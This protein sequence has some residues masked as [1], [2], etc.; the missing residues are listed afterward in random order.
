MLKNQIIIAIRNLTRQKG[1][2][3]I[4]ICGLTIGIT[5]CL[6]ILLYVS[7]EM[8][9]DRYH[10]NVDNIYRIGTQGII[11]PNEFKVAVT[12]APMGPAFI[13]EI[14]EVITAV[15]IR[16]FGF[17]VLTYKDKVFSEERFFSVDSTIFSI[18]T[19]PFLKGDPETALSKPNTVVITESMAHKYFGDEDPLNKLITADN[20]R[21]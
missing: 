2:T 3:F 20:R 8:S 17:P 4:N 14:P 9:Y 1:Y 6:L 10:E 11:G 16:N 15:R 7:D 18:F 13:N 19:I 5:C 21:S 12:P